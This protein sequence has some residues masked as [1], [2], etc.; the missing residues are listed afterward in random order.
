L[1]DTQKKQ[2]K[3]KPPKSIFDLNSKS[4]EE[5]RKKE[6]KKK[7]SWVIFLYPETTR[8]KNKNKW[9]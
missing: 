4:T 8:E 7:E 2:P 6:E 3:T 1:A 5:N 9:K